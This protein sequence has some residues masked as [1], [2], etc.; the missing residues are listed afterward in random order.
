MVLANA[1]LNAP[2]APASATEE[3]MPKAAAPAPA[4]DAPQL[5]LAL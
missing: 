1:D 4:T 5:A 2:T 3:A